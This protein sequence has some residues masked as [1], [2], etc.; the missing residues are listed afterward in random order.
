VTLPSQEQKQNMQLR[1]FLQESGLLP[2]FHIQM[3][4]E[5]TQLWQQDIHKG[6][7]Q[8]HM[9]ILTAHASNGPVWII[10]LTKVLPAAKVLPLPPILVRAHLLLRPIWRLAPPLL[11]NK[12]PTAPLR[13]RLTG[14]RKAL[15]TP[16]VLLGGC[17]ARVSLLTAWVHCGRLLIP[18]RG[19]TGGI[20]P[21]VC[22]RGLL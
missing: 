17:G 20:V 7:A 3:M 5:P 1:R 2:I 12:L 10:S 18:L 22:R 15:N 19:S 6:C 16:W 4:K 13:V 14:S 8:V 9:H 11:Q 21:R